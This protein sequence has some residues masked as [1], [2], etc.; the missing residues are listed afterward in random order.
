[1]KLYLQNY[2][3]HYLQ[4]FDKGDKQ[5]CYFENFKKRLYVSHHFHL[6]SVV[7]GTVLA[8]DPAS[9]LVRNSATCLDYF[10]KTYQLFLRIKVR[11][12]IPSDHYQEDWKLRL[13]R[14]KDLIFTDF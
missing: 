13:R 6:P 9:K 12:G 10:A 4:K 2:I 3:N 8:L 11:I 5:L 14:E 7:T 1:M